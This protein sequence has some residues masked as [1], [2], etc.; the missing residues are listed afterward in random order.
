MAWEKTAIEDAADYCDWLS[1]VTGKPYRLPTEA[2]WEKAARGTDGR[3]YPWRNDW[4]AERCNTKEGGRE[5]T[6]LVGL[7]VQGTS[8]YGLLDMAGNVWEWTSSPYASYPVQASRQS[9]EDDSA[10]PRVLK[11]GSWLDL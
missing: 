4:D 7:Y 6:S 10:A 2:E 11:G 1:A 5:G 8:P 9:Q 3:V